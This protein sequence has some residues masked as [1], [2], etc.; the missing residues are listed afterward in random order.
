MFVGCS[1]FTGKG[2]ENWNV[3]NVTNMNY[4][5]YECK[6]LDCDLSRW[7]VSGL[8]EAAYVFKSCIKFDCDL[9]NWDVSK[10]FN[11]EQM[12]NNC[13]SLKNIPSWYK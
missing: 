5:F 12:F 2:L 10:L 4:M 8:C 9:E 11:K 3:S 7:D 1:I 6:N 13:P